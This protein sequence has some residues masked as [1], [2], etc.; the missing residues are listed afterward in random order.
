MAVRQGKDQRV[1]QIVQFV[2][3]TPAE[4]HG[5][6][7]TVKAQ[8]AEE[9]A[10]KRERRAARE[11][12]LAAR[13]LALPDRKYAVI[14][15]DFE[16]DYEVRSR[17]TGMD[18][19]A[20]NHYPVSEDAHTARE[21][22][23]RTKDRFTIAAPNCF[24]AMWSTVPHLAIAIDVLRFR[25]FRYVSHYV[26]GKHRIGKGHWNRNKHE[27]LLIGIKGEVPCPAPGT[28]WDSLLIAEAAEHSAKPELFLE[29]IES[30]FPTAPKIELNRRGPPRPGVGRMG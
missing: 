20:A 28:Q 14:V 7:L 10:R 18:R 4:K 13:T 5:F 24:L 9:Q 8:R 29:M 6:R 25:G 11:T 1:R 17:L 16:W 2:P 3:S 15:E 19:H 23:D 27:V 21:I 12:E 30:Y 22:V 26:W